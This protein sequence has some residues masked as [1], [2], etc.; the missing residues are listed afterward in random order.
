M[1]IYYG[2]WICWFNK[3]LGIKCLDIVDVVKIFFGNRWA[4]NYKKSV[5]KLLKS[6]QNIDANISIKVHFL[7]SHLD[8][9][10]DNCDN[11]SDEQEEQFYQDLKRA[12]PGLVG[13]TNDGWLQLEYQKGFK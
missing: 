1:K 7:H 2:W 4:E 11:V 12:L 6:L 8:K 13:Q 5:E 3:W 9:F 10:P